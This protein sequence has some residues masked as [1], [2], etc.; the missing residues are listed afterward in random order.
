LICGDLFAGILTAEGEVYTWGWNIFGQLGL[1]DSAVGCTLN[2]MRVG[3][4]NKDKI[5]DIACGFNT[6]I[7]LT[8]SKQIYVWGKRMGIYPSFDLSL[9]GIEANT[10]ILISEHNQ[11]RPRL[12][13][14]NLMF[15]K[16]S[17]IVAG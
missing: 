7:A 13:K 10:H 16:I 8:D 11:D 5:M 6:C 15:Y 9:Q 14:E 4:L 12:L 2:P 1:K 17:K 3:F